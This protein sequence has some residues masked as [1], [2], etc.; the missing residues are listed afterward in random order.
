VVPHYQVPTHHSTSGPHI[1]APTPAYPHLTGTAAVPPAVPTAAGVPHPAL[2]S[3]SAQYPPYYGYPPGMPPSSYYGHYSY[4]YPPQMH[5][6]PA[7]AD[8]PQY[9]H[10]PYFPYPA[11]PPH[12]SAYAASPE[13]YPTTG[14]AGPNVTRWSRE[15]FPGSLH[16]S[17]ASLPTSYLR[18]SRTTPL[19]E[20]TQ[21]PLVMD[22]LHELR[23]S[24]E[25][26]DW[27]K[28]KL[29][30][31]IVRLGEVQKQAA[32][33]ERPSAAVTK[34]AHHHAGHIATNKPAEAPSPIQPTVRPALRF[35]NPVVWSASAAAVPHKVESSVRPTMKT[36]AK[37]SR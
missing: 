28:Q 1:V 25:E 18:G 37:N 33:P 2:T 32:S 5:G 29:A 22:L 26:A 14:I 17:H 10:S 36:A 8:S 27:A 3:G 11:M 31:T 13:Y 24:K 6:A 34:S 4:P 19:N 7:P 21:Q 23:R 9:P 16:S 15:G 30:E 12:P 20:L 35:S